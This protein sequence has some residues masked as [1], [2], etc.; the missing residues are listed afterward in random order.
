MRN[1]R[2][3]E[4]LKRQEGSMSSMQLA[5]LLTSHSARCGFPSVS[6]CSLTPCDRV[7]KLKTGV[8]RGVLISACY[9]IGKR[10][11]GRPRLRWKDNIRMDFVLYR[12]NG[13]VLAAQCTATFLR[14]IVLPNLGITR[15]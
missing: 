5:V 15:T 8:G 10:P 3:Q 2:R 14:S 7:G 1:V 12:I 13:V 9:T 4:A 6:L 11:S